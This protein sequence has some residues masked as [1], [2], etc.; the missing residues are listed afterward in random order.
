MAVQTPP[1]STT[2]VPTADNDVASSA[3]AL[4]ISRAPRKRLNLVFSTLS[5]KKAIPVQRSSS[6]KFKHWIGVYQSYRIDRNPPG[7][8]PNELMPRSS[9]GAS[10]QQLRAG[11]SGQDEAA[12]GTDASGHPTQSLLL[13]CAA[14]R[15]DI[16][17]YSG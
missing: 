15:L 11:L 2:S 12:Q 4:P 14:Q 1:L 13:L 17:S 16:P 6:L 8:P 9:S 10:G 5:I 7:V 3:H